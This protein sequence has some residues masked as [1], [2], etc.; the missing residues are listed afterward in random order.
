MAYASDRD[1]LVLEPRLFVD[2]L[3]VGQR[4]YEGEVSSSGTV[5]TA[6]SGGLDA[7]GVGA[8]HVVTVGGASYEVVER[9]S[10][11]ELS[12]SLLRATASAPLV[13]PGGASGVSGTGRVMTFSPQIELVHAQVLAMAG[14]EDAAV[15]TDPSRLVLIEAL[16]ALHLIYAS[17][18][19]GS[20]RDSMGDRASMY[21]GRFGAERARVRLMLDLDGDGEAETE[22]RLNAGVFVRA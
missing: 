6:A 22:R 10:D 11:A 9:L 18:S 5:L 7:A 8:G 3:W 4:L 20:G 21:R 2:L 1:L 15:V 16:G 17:A 19:A 13:A 12:V 14:I